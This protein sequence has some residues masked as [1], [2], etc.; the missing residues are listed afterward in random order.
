MLC[1][2]AA[3]FVVGVGRSRNFPPIKFPLISDGS[4]SGR[5]SVED[6]AASSRDCLA[7]RLN[8]E[9]G[10]QVDAQQRRRAENE[11]RFVTHFHGVFARV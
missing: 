11:S 2:G 9:F 6:D 5:E 1:P 8:D 4:R 10:L 7:N 3:D